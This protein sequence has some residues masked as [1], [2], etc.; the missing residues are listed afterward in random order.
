MRSIEKV[1]GRAKDCILIDEKIICILKHSYKTSKTCHID[2]TK[3]ALLIQLK[4]TSFKQTKHLH[5]SWTP[6]FFLHSEKP[7]PR[8]FEVDFRQM[9]ESGCQEGPASAGMA[10]RPKKKTHQK[11]SWA[12][13]A[14]AST[15]DRWYHTKTSQIKCSKANC[16]SLS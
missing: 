12:W 3:H 10:K 7:T 2:K 1:P 5:P 15:V 14:M 13:K 16:K 11:Q 4:S 9:S 6:V 8:H